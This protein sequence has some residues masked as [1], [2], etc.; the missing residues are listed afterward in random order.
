MGRSLRPFFI[1]KFSL[2]K[3]TKSRIKVFEP[4]EDNAKNSSIINSIFIS[5]RCV[6]KQSRKPVMK[7]SKVESIEETRNEN[8]KLLEERWGKTNIFKTFFLKKISE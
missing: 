5:Y 6:L 3:K 4:F 2:I 7:D 8:K 1:E